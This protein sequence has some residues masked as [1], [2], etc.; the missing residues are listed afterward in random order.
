MT[1]EERLDAA[2]R[3]IAQYAAHRGCIPMPSK[4][5]ICGPCI[6]QD[7]LGEQGAAPQGVLD[8]ESW[9]A[10]EGIAGAA[11]QPDAPATYPAALRE[12]LAEALEALRGICD[13]IPIVGDAGTGCVFCRVVTQGDG[14]WAGRHHPDWCPIAKGESILAKHKEKPCT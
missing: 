6:A 8:D 13:A 11:P 9:A 7:A 5:A 12:A 3:G 4:V 14:E 2:L 1:R 10:T